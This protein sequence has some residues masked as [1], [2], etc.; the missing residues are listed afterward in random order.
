MYFN[1]VIGAMLLMFLSGCTGGDVHIDTPA[2]CKAAGFQ[3][4]VSYDR[5]FSGI[6]CSNGDMM[7]RCYMTTDGLYCPITGRQPIYL[8][9]KEPK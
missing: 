9:L 8:K 1:L 6:A 2:T 7:G 4:I 5:V 3:G